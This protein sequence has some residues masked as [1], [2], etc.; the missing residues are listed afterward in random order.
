MPYNSNQRAIAFYGLVPGW[1]LLLG[2]VCFIVYSFTLPEKEIL[3]DGQRAIYTTESV[4]VP[5]RHRATCETVP[6][7]TQV[8]EFRMPVLG[9]DGNPILESVQFSHKGKG[10]AKVLGHEMH[11][12]RRMKLY[13]VEYRPRYEIETTRRFRA[14]ERVN[15]LDQAPIQRAIARGDFDSDVLQNIWIDYDPAIKYEDTSCYEI[16]P[17]VKFDNGVSP[18]IWSIT[19]SIVATVFG[20]L[21]YWREYV[22]EG[23]SSEC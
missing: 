23:L 2:Y 11:A 15:Y 14:A 22:R 12:I 16:V 3:V 13:P 1:G 18:A 6:L 10:T 19:G 4:K 5:A 8:K 7:E 20:S 9:S 17:I 21:A